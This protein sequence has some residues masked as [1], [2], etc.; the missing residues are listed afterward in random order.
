MDQVQQVSNYADN[1]QDM[2]HH[3]NNQRN[4]MRSM[5]MSAPK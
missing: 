4:E 1:M 3:M 5:P 2:Y